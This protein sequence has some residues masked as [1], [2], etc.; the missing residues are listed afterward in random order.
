MSATLDESLFSNFFSGAPVLNIPGRTFPVSS[1]YLEDILEE[2]GHLVEEGSRVAKRD[3][4]KRE[5][6]SLMVTNQGGTKRRETA[7][8]QMDEGLS[9]DFPGYSVATRRYVGLKIYA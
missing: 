6:V 2:T 8:Y 4:S 9:D 5:T 1:F 3:W 7:D